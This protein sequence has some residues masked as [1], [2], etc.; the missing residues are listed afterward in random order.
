M[1]LDVS[2]F[3]IKAFLVLMFSLQVFMWSKTTHILPKLEIVP[4]VPSLNQTRAMALG[5][6]QLYFRYLA[7]YIQNCGD[8]FGRFTALKN[9][10]YKLLLKWMLLLDKLD[11]K[12]NFTPAIA[13]YYYSNT[14]NIP[15]VRYIIEYLEQ[16]YDLDPKT[17]WWWLSQ[18]I[19]LAQSKLK[20]KSLSL[21]LAY[22]LSS[23]PAEDIP[24]WARQMPAFILAE[25][26]DKEQAMLIIKD[27][28]TRY[29]NYSKR[30][31]DFMNYFIRDRL[32]FL[33]ES[34]K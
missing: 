20:D 7:L 22:K 6:E 11:S 23:S 31:L 5:D 34:I 17:K 16:H 4:E 28:A 24:I 14:Q 12:S 9:Y 29:R 30:E 27:V 32:G 33:N 13:S 15:D 26:G 1:I 3:K 10:D 21:R 2:S 19:I 8:S 25:L 18:G